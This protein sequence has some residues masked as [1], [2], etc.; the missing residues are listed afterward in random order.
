MQALNEENKTQG[1]LGSILQGK[2]QL[3]MIK[4]NLMNAIKESMAKASSKREGRQANGAPAPL[5]AKKKKT[6][7]DT[8]LTKSLFEKMMVKSREVRVL[9]KAVNDLEMKFHY[10]RRF[11]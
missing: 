2:L 6:A 5:I 1:G 3:N 4:G 10:D 7:L 9:E 11:K 8:H